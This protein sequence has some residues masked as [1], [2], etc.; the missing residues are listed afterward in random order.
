MFAHSWSPYDATEPWGSDPA[1]IEG[2]VAGLGGEG[3]QLAHAEVDLE[4]A[5]A[6]R[7]LVMRAVEKFGSLDT[8]VVNH[9][10][11]SVGGLAELI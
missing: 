9:A 2:V 6:P 5:E 4:D 3:S 8:L 1:G 11:S 7:L 10:R